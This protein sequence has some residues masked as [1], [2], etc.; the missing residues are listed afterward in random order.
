MESKKLYIYIW[1][2]FQSFREEDAI[3]G[4]P[5]QLLNEWKQ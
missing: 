3:P 2:G 4:S 1:F 5:H